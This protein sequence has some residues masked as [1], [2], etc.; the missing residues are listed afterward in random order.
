MA[1]KEVEEEEVYVH[2]HLGGPRGKRCGR[3][4]SKG[5][6]TYACQNL[7]EKGVI[8]DGTDPRDNKVYSSGRC[9]T[10]V[11]EGCKASDRVWQSDLLAYVDRG[12]GKALSCWT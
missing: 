7:V 8:L 1:G 11:E 10:C 4:R 2:A 5:R 3:E 6:R 12:N 9:A